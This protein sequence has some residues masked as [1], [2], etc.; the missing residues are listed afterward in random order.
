MSASACASASAGEMRAGCAAY[1]A[2][3]SARSGVTR[4]SAGATGRSSRASVRVLVTDA[5][6]KARSRL[7]QKPIGASPAAD[8]TTPRAAS[9]SATPPPVLLPAT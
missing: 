6:Q 5:W 4:S 1:W 3:S 7:L 2:K 8:A 9:S